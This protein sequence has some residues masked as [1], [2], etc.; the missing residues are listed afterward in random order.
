MK[1]VIIEDETAAVTSLRAMLTENQVVQV[2]VIAELESV[3]ECVDWFRNNPAPDLI[4][5]DIHLADGSAFGLLNR[6]T[7]RR[8]LFLQR[9]ST[10]MLCRL[11]R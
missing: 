5:M 11:F 1:A 10:P 2:D 3:E 7:Y 6:W 4:F 9:P 8:L